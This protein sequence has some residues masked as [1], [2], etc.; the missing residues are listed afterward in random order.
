MVFASKRGTAVGPE[1]VLRPPLRVCTACSN[2]PGAFLTDTRLESIKP[3]LRL[4]LR[5]AATKADGRGLITMDEMRVA[6]NFRGSAWVQITWVGATNHFKPFACFRL[7]IIC[8][9]VDDNVENATKTPS[10]EGKH[11]ARHTR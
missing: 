10:T 1:V 4:S 9:M 11:E 3:Q 8:H 5:I 7:S 2:A 6:T